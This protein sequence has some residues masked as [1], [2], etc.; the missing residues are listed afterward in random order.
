FGLGLFRTPGC[1]VFKHIEEVRAGHSITFTRDKKVVTKYWNLESKVHTDSIEDTS[2]H[3]LS[4]LQDTVKR[5]L[6]ADVPL[7]CMLSGGLD[8][9]GIT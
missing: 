5:Q 1:G 3:I 8:S 4:I 9:S 7:V 6:I 2:S